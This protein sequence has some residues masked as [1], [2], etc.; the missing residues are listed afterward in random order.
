MIDKS[1]YL[2]IHS[3]FISVF[4]TIYHHR[5]DVN[6]LQNGDDDDTTNEQSDWERFAQE[7]YELLVAEE[8]AAEQADG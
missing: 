4:E 2:F 3:N 5:N 6:D 7:E 8:G 1:W